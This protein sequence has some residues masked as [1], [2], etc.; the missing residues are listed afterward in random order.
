MTERTDPYLD[1][2][3][4]IGIGTISA[5]LSPRVKIEVR[6]MLNRDGFNTAAVFLP[7][8]TAADKPYGRGLFEAMRCVCVNPAAKASREGREIS[9]L[10]FALPACPWPD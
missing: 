2:D 8:S 3:A 1:R 4:D 6:S 9:T 7:E 10:T 5:W